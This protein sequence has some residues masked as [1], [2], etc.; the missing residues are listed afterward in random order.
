M[1]L[2]MLGIALALLSAFSFSMNMALIRRGVSTATPG[3]AALI[4]VIVGVPLFLTAAAVSGQLARAGEISTAGLVYLAAAGIMH[5]VIGRYANYRALQ[6]VGANMAQVVSTLSTP[7]GVVLALVLLDEGVTLLM[8][9]GILLLIFA[10]LA[11]VERNSARM[12]TPSGATVPQQR[13][14][15]RMLEGY[16]WG[17]VASV[18]YGTSPLLIRAA[19]RDTN[20]GLLGGAIA[21]AAAAIVLIAIMAA[22]ARIRELRAADRTGLRLMITG[23]VSVFL[24]QM[25]RFAALGV[26]PVAIVEPLIR[27][28][29]VF[30]VVI[31]Y[32][33]N[34]TIERFGRGV[35]VGVALSVVGALTLAAGR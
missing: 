34:R 30:T 10:P 5:F 9:A 20:M 1:G 28:G 19:V 16:L 8:W 6:A 12:P 15:P 11:M 18:G 24:A 35:Y 26:A 23:G 7:L 27:A 22:P 25:F 17:A 2:P 3:Q 29:A 13:F 21:Y 4:T 32:F 31:S 33:M 14:H